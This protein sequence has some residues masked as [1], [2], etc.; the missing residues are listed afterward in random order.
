MSLHRNGPSAG[1]ASSGTFL[2]AGKDWE[3][4]IDWYEDRIAGTERSEDRELAYVEVPDEL[5]QQGRA[6]VNAWIANRIYELEGLLPSTDLGQENTVG[7]TP[8]IPAQ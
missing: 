6:K 3:V 5:W 7:T 1:S 4:W 2:E 8:S